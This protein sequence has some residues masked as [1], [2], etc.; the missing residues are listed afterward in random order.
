MVSESWYSV[1]P[2]LISRH[3]AERCSCYLIIDPF[4]GAGGNI[5]Q[6]AKTCELGMFKNKQLNCWF[7]HF[8]KLLF[9][10]YFQS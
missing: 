6:F 9:L 3:I 8:N 4:C 2:E 7:I 5:I 10:L 1:T